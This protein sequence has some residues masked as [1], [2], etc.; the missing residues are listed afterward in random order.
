MGKLN[1]NQDAL[2]VMIGGGW[3]AGK[4]SLTVKLAYE[5]K[6]ANIIHTDVVR[7]C[8]REV[9]D[10]ES[11]FCISLSTYES[12]K[13]AGLECTEQTL[14]EGFLRQCKLIYPSIKR[15][16]EEAVDFGKNTIIEGMH[17]HPEL[18]KGISEKYNCKY[19]WLSFSEGH[20]DQRVK[21]RCVSNYKNR[22]SGKYLS[23]KNKFKIILL[24]NI[25]LKTASS[26]GICII[27]NT[28]Y[29]ADQAIIKH[30]QEMSTESS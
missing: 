5:L 10:N 3:S 1:R 27:D 21:E 20:Y 11:Q 22:D 25:L 4:S 13:D 28:Q 17:L 26:S 8:L 19:F 2:I 7:S 9:L 14:S 15:S 18:Y 23:S 12:W 29:N 24:N 16:I 6:M 30:I